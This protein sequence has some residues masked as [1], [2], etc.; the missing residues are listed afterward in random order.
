MEV[1]NG[2][3]ELLCWQQERELVRQVYA[4]CREPKLS[5]DFATQDQLKRAALSIMNNIAEGYGRYRSKEFIR[6][7]DISSASAM[8]V[9]TMLYVLK[10]MD[11]INHDTFEKLHKLSIHQTNLTIGFIKY[12]NRKLNENK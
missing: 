1:V 2:F 4:Q 11:Y 6:F 5:K 9:R 7:L 10:D 8:E 3:E 12:L